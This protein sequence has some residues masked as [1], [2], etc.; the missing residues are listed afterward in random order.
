MKNMINFWNGVNG[1]APGKRMK[2][3]K[4]LLRKQIQELKVRSNAWDILTFGWY[5]KHTKKEW[6]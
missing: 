1:F 6:N 2:S 4:L 3:R 5:V